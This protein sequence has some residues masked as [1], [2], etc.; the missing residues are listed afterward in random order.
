MA[1]E[2]KFLDQLRNLLRI[3][4]KTGSIS[5]SQMD[6]L[7]PEV[8]AKTIKR[9][10][11]LIKESSLVGL[12][13]PP[14]PP[15]NEVLYCPFCGTLWLYNS[16]FITAINTKIFITDRLCSTCGD[17]Y[18]HYLALMPGFWRFSGSEKERNMD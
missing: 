15:H 17:V 12:S 10:N 18:L 6:L 8:S 1:K 2:R 4:S 13:A 7:S 16:S 3:G 14:T 9:P 11:E 5:K